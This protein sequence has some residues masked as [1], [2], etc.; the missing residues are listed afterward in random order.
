M[1]KSSERR[2]WGEVEQITAL[3]EGGLVE[4]R[5][6]LREF[7]RIVFARTPTSRGHP[8]SGLFTDSRTLT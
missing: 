2:E 5:E 6:R 8:R 1:R 4:G 7:I 3:S